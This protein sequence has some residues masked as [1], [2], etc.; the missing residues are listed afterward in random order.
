[1][2]KPAMY[3]YNA[4]IQLWLSQWLW[5]LQLCH[6]SATS[7]RIFLVT[8]QTCHNHNIVLTRLSQDCHK[9]VI[10]LLIVDNLITTMYNLD[11]FMWGAS[12]IFQWNWKFSTCTLIIR[13]LYAGPKVFRF[14][15]IAKCYNYMVD[16]S[17][18]YLFI[19]FLTVKNLT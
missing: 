1:M 2:Y 15:C 17:Y 6:S 13:T 14:H 19:F 18:N 7:W 10:T 9:L 12:L 4:I 11:I 5:Q 16:V 3:A 8:L